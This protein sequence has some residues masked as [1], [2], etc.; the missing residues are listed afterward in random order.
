MPV[1]PIFLYPFLT[2]LALLFTASA[3]AGS[4]SGQA[5]SAAEAPIVSHRPEG[6]SQWLVRYGRWQDVVP[7]HASAPVTR[8]LLDVGFRHRNGRGGYALVYRHQPIRL[9]FGE[10]GHNGYLH[11]LGGDWYWRGDSWEVELGG[12]LQASSNLFRHGRFHREA[13]VLRGGV[14]YPAPVVDRIGLGGDHRFGGFRLYPRLL[15]RFE[16]PGTGVLTLDLPRALTFDSERLPWQLRL[17]RQGDKWGALDASR[18]VKSAVYLQ[19]WQLTSRHRQRLDPRIFLDIELGVS[20]DTRIRYLDLQ[21][22]WR[23]EALP[24]A[25]FIVVGLGLDW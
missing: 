1:T 7:A 12:G 23:E 5:W 11:R 20:F 18:Q 16:W 10:P 21:R 8:G 17:E 4:A 15:H 24:S 3:V 9:R 14:T 13:L 25:G 6:D 19:E 22:G 2:A